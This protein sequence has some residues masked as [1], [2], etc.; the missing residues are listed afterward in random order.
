MNLNKHSN[1]VND[2]SKLTIDL[3][4]VHYKNEQNNSTISLFDKFD[5]KRQSKQ[6]LSRSMICTTPMRYNND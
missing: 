5:S 4:Q 6:T 2:E 3:P 1:L